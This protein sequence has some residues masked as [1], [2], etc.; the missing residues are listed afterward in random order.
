MSADEVEGGD[1]DASC[2]A[3][4]MCAA[5]DVGSEKT[6]D[7]LALVGDEEDGEK[8]E[9]VEEKEEE[10]AESAADKTADETEDKC[11]SNPTAWWR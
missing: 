6:V 7:G 4:S 8:E 1:A 9:K 3:I 11:K 5:G 2:S 10:K